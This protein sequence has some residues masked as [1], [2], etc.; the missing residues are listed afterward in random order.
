[1]KAGIHTISAEQYHADTLVDLPTLSN[2]IAKILVTQSP[3]HAWCAHSRLNP[4]YESDDSSRFDLGSAAHAVLLEKDFS[5]IQFIEADDWRT[6]EAKSQRDMA[7]AKGL[8]PVL[9]KYENM[10]RSMV[11]RAHEKIANSE[12]KGIFDDGKPEQT[13]LWQDGEAW[14]R[15]RL[16][17]LRTDQRVILDYKTTDSASPEA[18]VR[19]ISQMG[20]DIQASFYKRGLVACGGPEDAVFVFLFQE[21]EP[22][23]ACCLVALSTMYIEMANE[24]VDQAIEIWSMCMASGKWPSYPSE[25]V[26]AEPPPWEVTKY[27]NMMEERA[28]GESL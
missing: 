22:P 18:C 13:L 28:L 10:L 27:M 15:A 24:K 23:Y 19:K 17:W 25:V 9:H 12:L 3:Q 20:Y 11:S 26:I 7:R 6:K 16:D 1:M 5:K 8:L 14:C 21:I 4:N 2:S